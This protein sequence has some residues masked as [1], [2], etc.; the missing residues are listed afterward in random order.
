VLAALIII[1][2]SD[3]LG[4][5]IIAAIVKGEVPHTTIAY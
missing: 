5:A 4:K 3:E 1:G 2:A